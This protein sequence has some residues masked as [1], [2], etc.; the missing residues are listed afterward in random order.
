MVISISDSVGVTSWYCHFK[1]RNKCRHLTYEEVIL[2]D[3]EIEKENLF[4]TLLAIFCHP[5]FLESA[6]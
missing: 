2:N 4:F 3:N 5:G 1:F 6:G